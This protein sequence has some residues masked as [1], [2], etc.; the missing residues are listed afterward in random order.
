LPSLDQEQREVFINNLCGSVQVF[1]V[2]NGKSVFD[3]ELANKI[4]Q[5][6]VFIFNTFGRV[7][8]GGLFILNGLILTIDEEFGQFFP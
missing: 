3:T 1:I 4:V 6:A 5:L 7:T 8:T 2:R